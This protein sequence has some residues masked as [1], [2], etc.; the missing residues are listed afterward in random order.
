[1]YPNDF[2]LFL[3]L[4]ES[5]A[6]SAKR[7]LGLFLVISKYLKF[8]FTD[9]ES[10]LFPASNIN[11]IDIQMDTT[12][13]DEKYVLNISSELKLRNSRAL[14]LFRIKN[15]LLEHLNWL[16]S[17]MEFFNSN[18]ISQNIQLQELKNMLFLSFLI[19]NASL[20]REHSI[21]VHHRVDF[22]LPP[23][24][25]NHSI[26]QKNKD[27]DWFNLEIAQPVSKL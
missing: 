1:M 18:L 16:T 23:N 7:Y 25:L 19:C 15:E 9:V 26:S 3:I 8:S 17:I 24:V 13:Y 5:Y 4:Q 20:R 14:G 10:C 11:E 22:P 27:F 21:G 12:S 6:E 2:N